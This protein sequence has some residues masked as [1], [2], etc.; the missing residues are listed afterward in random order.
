M[1]NQK[2]TNIY[3]LLSE[4][5]LTKAKDVNEFSKW[6]AGSNYRQNIYGLLKQSK[7]KG[8]GSGY[9]EFTELTGYGKRSSSPQTQQAKDVGSGYFGSPENTQNNVPSSIAR[10]DNYSRPGSLVEQLNQRDKEAEEAITKPLRETAKKVQNRQFTPQKVQYVDENDNVVDEDEV[11]PIMPKET[12]ED[13]LNRMAYDRLQAA[14]KVDLSG[15]ISRI[16]K[17][18]DAAFKA[19]G[20]RYMQKMQE[21]PLAF[22]LS[23]MSPQSAPAPGQAYDFKS[24]VEQDPEYANKFAALQL[25]KDADYIQKAAGQSKKTEGVGGWFKDAAYGAKEAAKKVSTW[26]NGDSTVRTFGPLLNAANKF[27]RGEQL[28]DSE[29]ELLEA[30]AI[31]AAYNG[32]YGDDVSSGVKAGQITV[33]ALPFMAEMLA[34]PASGTGKA[35]QKKFV[36]K[37]MTELVKG[38][39]KSIAKKQGRKAAAKELAKGTLARVGGDLLGAAVMAGTTGAEGV[40]GDTFRRMQGQSQYGVDENGNIQ[41][42]GR[43]ENEENPLVAA[44][45]AFGARTIENHSEMVGAY[46]GPVLGVAGE[47]VA[48]GLS[49]M[50]LGGVVDFIKSMGAT[51]GAKLVDNFFEKTKWD[52]TIGEYAEEV[53]GGIENAL[54][55]GDQTLDRDPETGVFNGEQNLET[56][57]SVALMGGFMSTLHTGT[58]ALSYTKGKQQLNRAEYLASES[59]GDKWSGIKQEIDKSTDADASKNLNQ[60]LSDNS[61]SDEQ[62]AAVR[63]YAKRKETLRGVLYGEEARK[64]ER[65]QEKAATR[66]S[67]I[68][69][70]DDGQT[71]VQ[72]NQNGEVI[73]EEKFGDEE[74]AKAHAD[75][76][77]MQRAE[78]DF[79]D[80]L[81][82]AIEASEQRR[83]AVENGT[84]DDFPLSEEMEARVRAMAMN[85]I[86]P[87]GVEEGSPEYEAF[88]RNM[89]TPGT[90]ENDILQEMMDSFDPLEDTY[91]T[92][93]VLED[94]DR[95]EIDKAIKT[96]PVKRTERQQKLVSEVAWR[97]HQYNFPKGELHPEQS[98]TDGQTQAD[99]DGAGTEYAMPENMV[100]AREDMEE[101]QTALDDA[102]AQNS[103]LAG[104]VNETINANEPMS[105]EDIVAG[106]VGR[107]SDEERR[108]VCDF[109]NAQSRLQ[110]YLDFTDKKMRQFVTRETSKRA[111]KGT[112]N[113]AQQ[114]NMVMVSDGEHTYFLVGGDVSTDEN[115]R[116]IGDGGKG[117]VVVDEQGNIVPMGVDASLTIMPGQTY[118][119]YSAGLLQQMQVKTTAEMGYQPQAPTEQPSPN[120]SEEGNAEAQP[121][122]TDNG[123]QPAAEAGQEQTG[124]N[125]TAGA[126]PVAPAGEPAGTGAEMQQQAVEEETTTPPAQEIPTDKEGV[127]LYEQGVNVDDAIGDIQNDGFDPAQYADLAINEAQ[128]ELSKMKEPK[129]RADLVKNNARRKELQNTIDY[130]TSLKERYSAMQS[131]QQE[132]EQNVEGEE[133]VNV[134]EVENNESGKELSLQEQIERREFKGRTADER[135][136][137]RIE[138]LKA[139]Y[140]DLFDDDF[141]YAQTPMELASMFVGRN[142]MLSRESLES[143]LGYPL[144]INTDEAWAETLLAKKGEGKT[145]KEVAHAAWESSENPIVDEK[146]TAR[147][148]DDK[149]IHDALLELFRSADNKSDV[150][151]YYINSR[152]EAAKRALEGQKRAAAEGVAA[153]APLTAAEIEEM[154]ATLPFAKPVE[155][156]DIPDSP[157]TQLA[158]AVAELS[159]EEGMPEIGLVDTDRMSD[160]DWYEITSRLF[161]GAF[162]SQ[163]EI[164]KVR[165]T[166]LADGLYIVDDTGAITIYSDSQTPEELKYK[167]E[168]IKNENNGRS[169][170]EKAGEL[171]TENVQRPS[172]GTPAVEA[173]ETP[174]EGANGAASR[175]E[176][177]EVEDLDDPE[178]IGSRISEDGETVEEPSSNGTVYKQDYLIDGKHKVTKV[179]EPDAKRNYTGSYYMFDGKRYG[180]LNEIVREID[181]R[182]EGKPSDT[183][184]Q[185]QTDEYLQ[186][187]NAEE[188]AI[189]KGVI[190]QLQQEIDAAVKERDKAASALEKARAKESDKATDMFSDDNAFKQEGQLFDSSEMPTDRSQEGVNRRTSAERERL[191]EAQDKL[192]KL[193]SE[194]ERNSRIRGAL[195]NERRQTRIRERQNQERKKDIVPLQNRSDEELQQM[196]KSMEDSVGGDIKK[197]DGNKEYSDIVNILQ[198]R[199]N[200][201]QHNDVKNFIE[202]TIDDGDVTFVD[203]LTPTEFDKL[204]S[205]INENGV[206]DAG[207]EIEKYVKSLREKYPVEQTETPSGEPEGTVADKPL[208]SLAEVKK[209]MDEIGYKGSLSRVM[210]NNEGKKFVKYQASGSVTPNIVFGETTR[211]DVYRQFHNYRNVMDVKIPSDID[212]EFSREDASLK[213][214]KDALYA[215]DRDEIKDILTEAGIPF[216]DVIDSERGSRIVFTDKKN[217]NGNYTDWMD[218]SDPEQA[219][220]DI[221]FVKAK[222]ERYKS[223]SLQA[224]ETVAP[225]MEE[226]KDATGVEEPKKEGKNPSGNK[227]V[228][229]ERYEELKKRM[230]DKLLG[231]MN[232]GVDPEILAIGVEMAVYHIEKGARK[233]ADFARDMIEDLGDVIRPYLKAFYNGARDLPE[234]E[235]LSKEMDDYGTVQSFDV[236][237]FDKTSADPMEQAKEIRDE[238]K[239]N[240]DVQKAKENIK[241]VA[242]ENNKKKKNISSQQ[243]AAKQQQDLFNLNTE[244]DEQEVRRDEGLPAEQGSRSE[245]E[246]QEG[247]EPERVREGGSS[248]PNRPLQ[249]GLSDTVEETEAE[250][251]PHE[252]KNQRNNRNE[253]GKDYAP[254]SAT[255]RVKANIAAIKLLKQL[256]AEDR[257][258]TPEEM[259]VLKQYSGWGGL[260]GAFNE[261]SP[262]Y[263][264]VRDVLDDAEYDSAAM[265]INSA[266]YTP[267]SVIDRLWDVATKL[268]FKGGNILESSAG[269]GNIIASI[270]ESMNERSNIEMVE[271]DSISGRI[272]AKLYPD[273]KVNIKGFEDTRIENGSVD[274]AITNVPFVTGLKVRDEVDTDL[275]RQFG[276]IHDFVIAKNIRKLK[277]G[278]IG[279]F[280]TTSNTLDKSDSL[281]EW[282]DGKGD[283]DV[284]GVFRLNNET[285]GGTKV[286]SD[287]IVVRKRVNGERHPDAIDVMQSS[288]IR[289]GEYE[290]QDG[291]YDWKTGKYETKRTSMRVNNYLNEH[292]EDM[293]GE[294]AFGY[295]KGDT[296]RP[297]SYGLYPS[298]KNQEQLL[299]A[300]VQK[301]KNVFAAAKQQPTVK[302]E[303]TTVR[304]G[305]MFVK[306][307]K[308]YVSQ[309]G[310]AVPYAVKKAKVKGKSVEECVKDYVAIRESLGDVLKYQLDNESDKGLKPLLDKLNKAY[311]DFVK[312]YG[313]LHKNVAISFL[314]D[315]IEFPDIAALENYSESKDIEGNKIVR[316]GKSKVFEGR[317]LR[318]K[319]EPKP[320]TVKDGVLASVQQFGKIDLGWIAK[321]VPGQTEASVRTE[322]LNSGYGFEDPVTKKV[323]VRYEYLSGNVREKLRQARENNTD[324]RYNKNIEALEKVLPMD[325]PAHLI[326]FSLGSS[327]IDPKL[328]E[329][330]VKDK[331]GCTVRLVNVGG[332][333]SMEVL[334]GEYDEKNRAGGVHSELLGDTIP[335][336]K[337]FEAAINNRTYKVQRTF[338]DWDGSKHTETDKAATQ[339]CQNRIGEIKDEFNEWAKGR[340]QT[341]VEMAEKMMRVYNDKFNSM[342]PKEVDDTFVPE[343]FEGAVDYIHL[344]PHQSKAVMRAVTEPVMLAHQVGAGKTFTLITTAMEMRRLGTAKKPMIV[345]QNATVGQFV[346]AAKVLYPN[347]KILSLTE[348][349][350]DA[351][352][353]RSFYGKIK[354]NDW[355]MIVIPQSTFER[356]PDSPERQEEFIQEKI[357]D[358]LHALEAAR[359][360]KADDRMVKQ[361][362]REIDDLEQE[363]DDIALGR[364]PQKGKKGKKKDEEKTKKNTAARAKEQLD[365]HADDVMYFDDMGIDALLIDEAHEYKRLGFSTTMGRGVKGIDP[366]GSKKAAGVYL[367]TRGILK[368]NG[369][370]NVVF[371]TGTPISNTAAEIWTFMKYLMPKESMME[372]EIWYFDD[373]VHNFGKVAQSLEFATNGKFKENTRF[374]AYINKPELIRIWSTVADTVLAKDMPSVAEKLP[375]KENGKDQDVFLPQTQSLIGIMRAVRKKLEEFEKMSGAEKRANSSVPLVMYGLA[376]RA[377]IDPR[378][379]DA[380]AMDEPNSKTNKA[381]DEIVKD[382][383]ATDSYKGTVAVFCDMQN[384]PEGFNIFQEMKRKLMEKGVPENKIAIITSGMTITQKE[385][386][387]EQVNSGDIRVIMGSTQT[388]GTG[389]NI[390]ERLHLLIHM[391]APDRP[392]DYTQRNG[393]ILRQGNLHKEW[394]RPIRIL[395]F[396]V[397]DSLDVTSYQRLKTKSGFIDSIMD[398]KGALANNQVDRTLEE[399][400]EGLFDNPV[401]VLSG[402]QYALKKTQAERELRKWQSKKQQWEAD[403]IY[404]ENTIRR[405]NGQNKEAEERIK[406]YDNQIELAKKHFPD[407]KAKTITVKGVE[408]KTE[409]ELQK[410][411]SEQVGKPIRER[412]EKYRNDR[413]FTG[414][415]VKIPMKFDDVNVVVEVDIERETEYVQ[416]KGLKTT[417]HTIYRYNIPELGIDEYSIPRGFIKDIVNDIKEDISAQTTIDRREFAQKGIEKRTADNEQLEARRSPTFKDE[418]KLES[419]R[420]KVDEYTEEMRKEMA[421]KEA[422]YAAMDAEDVDL[423]AIEDNAEEEDDDSGTRLREIEEN[424]DDVNERFNRE[425]KMQ[426]EGTLPA[427]HVYYL[428]MP[429]DAL[430]STDFPNVPI[431]LSASHL[432]DKAN[433]AHHPFD[434]SEMK[435]LVK[436]LQSPMAVFVYGD[437]DKSQNVIVEIEHDGKQFVVGIHFNQKR[438]GAIVSDIRGLYPKDNAEWLNWI[439][440]GKMLYRDKKKIQALINKQRRTLAEVDYLDLNSVANIIENFENPKLSDKKS[441]EISSE[442]VD[443]RR[444]TDGNGGTRLREGSA[445]TQIPEQ[446]SPT[447]SLSQPAEKMKEHL[448]KLSKKIGVKVVFHDDAS[449]ITNAKVKE[450]LQKGRFVAGWYDPKDN[451]VHF[452]M[453]N[454]KDRYEAEKTILHEVVG[455]KGMRALLGEEGYRTFM[456][457]LWMDKSPAFE[458]MHQWVV[459]NYMRYGGNLYETM[460]EWFAYNVVEPSIPKTMWDKVMQ[461]MGDVL[462]KLGFM[463]TPN[464]KDMKYMLWLSK[465]AIREG[466]A[467]SE[468][469]RNAL[470]AKLDLETRRRAASYSKDAA[471][472]R[473]GF[474]NTPTGETERQMY[475]NGLMRKMFAWTEAH[476]DYMA[477]AKLLM[478]AILKGRSVLDKFNF[479]MKENHSD[480]KI[481]IAEDQYVRDFCKPMED[482]I[483]KCI[484]A[485]GGK[486]SEAYE[487]LED[488]MAMKHG[489][490]RN[491]EFFVRDWLEDKRKKTPTVKD[492][493]EEAKRDFESAA[494]GIYQAFEDGQ[495]ETEA[496]RDSELRKALQDSYSSMLD[497]IEGGWAATKSQPTDNLAEWLKGLD[498]YI[499]EHID[500]EYNPNEHDYSGLTS[501]NDNVNANLN[502]NEEYD[503]DAVIGYVM[504]M[505]GKMG[506]ENVDELWKQKERMTQFALDIEHEAGLITDK[507]YKKVSQMFHWYM[508]LRKWDEDM[509][510]DIWSYMNTKKSTY[511]GN[512]LMKAKGRKSRAEMPIGTMFAMGGNAI[513]RAA[514]NEVKKSFA[515]FVRKYE[516]PGEDALVTELDAWVENLG[517]EENPDWVYS[518]PDIPEGASQDEIIQA[519]AEWSQHMLD[520]MQEGRAKRVIQGDSIPYRFENKKR[521]RP[522]HIVEVYEDGR[523]H[524]FIV[525]DNP[526][527]A[528]AING[529]LK[530]ETK[531]KL[532]AKVNR[533]MSSVFTSYSPT[534]MARNAFRDAEFAS[535]MLSVKEGW[536][537]CQKFMKN[538]V[539]VTNFAGKR[540][541]MFTLF[542]KFR[543]GTLDDSNKM[544]RYFKEFAENGGITGY[545]MENNAERWEKEILAGVKE[546]GE[547]KVVGITKNIV[548]KF[549]EGVEHAGEAIENAAR[550]ATY[551]TSREDGRTITKSVNDAKEVSVNFNRKGAGYKTESLLNDKG[552][553][554]TSAVWA[555]KTAQ[556]MRANTLFYNASLQGIVNSVGNAVRKPWWFAAKFAIPPMV[557][558]ALIPV[559]NAWVHAMLDDDDDKV[560]K[561]PYADLPEYTRRMNMCLYIGHGKFLMIPLSIEHR[562]FFGLGDIMA[563]QT[564]D[565]RLKSVDYPFAVD[566]VR[567]MT[568]FSPVD[569]N[570]KE[571]GV[572]GVTGWGVGIITPAPI[573]PLVNA[574]FNKSWTGS[575]IQ[576][577]NAYG[578]SNLPE[579]QKAKD[580]TNKTLIGASRMWHELWGGDEA[581]RAGRNDDNKY[582]EWIG[583]ISPAKME[584]VVEQYFGE[585]GKLGTGVSDMYSMIFGDKDADLRKIPIVKAFMT[586]PNDN[587]QFRRANTKYWRY[588]D[589]FKEVEQDDRQYRARIETN[590]DLKLEYENKFK[591]TKRYKQ[592][593]LYDPGKGGEGFKYKKTIEDLQ[594][595]INAEDDPVQK[596]G[597]T[598]EKNAYVQELVE[599]LDGVE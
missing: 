477:S 135:R 524:F 530:P 227:L 60:I 167:V 474:T 166:V 467:W 128:T 244:E 111:F 130:Y 114:E 539:K 216:A 479:Y 418:D 484:A 573:S 334:R 349:D 384:G 391:D 10:Q 41:Y 355:D 292:P 400:E 372:Q 151:D 443:A 579:Y 225:S 141:S 276:N 286:T 370:K 454:I 64:K 247:G 485:I 399:E 226:I 45:K 14:N 469:Q 62:K 512:T 466:D 344:Y 165:D 393:R 236:A 491:R 312:K 422:K 416:G 155:G 588:R 501:F 401:A 101:A 192:N 221:A 531:H 61:L 39:V 75:M 179:D 367:K 409:E 29:R 207:G 121:Q 100:H 266:Y 449:T 95:D 455:H 160:D 44:A 108:V 420:K 577:E 404:I 200:E 219:R 427:G 447:R 456:R 124:A 436:A 47:A 405:N 497:R 36:S 533:F 235:E 438:H 439:T 187:R 154:E 2:V 476:Q 233:F 261:N 49:K 365:R 80:D 35:L 262:Y 277:E 113:G 543:D 288:V 571:T 63:E 516:K 508:P 576:R 354:Y 554:T 396:G 376:K 315:D 563:G 377:A 46:F 544:E 142:R 283:T 538:Y 591:K 403:Q 5:G 499:R 263:N 88:V 332:T 364:E 181:S 70:A 99:L 295:E 182:A 110:G 51:K 590:P 341:D 4:N 183:V 308:I 248:E 253:R 195:D 431:E 451:S 546:I 433:T 205:L 193:Q 241:V 596:K 144:G 489:L 336:S 265:S 231:Q 254:T 345:V 310:K 527:A 375:E 169:N 234:M 351:E 55:V 212:A 429:S 168:Y 158:K 140:G 102:M 326:D 210:T 478:D 518:F 58:G 366:A 536:D 560:S 76:L 271:I 578:G 562:A 597:L 17:E 353:R 245:S 173:A 535:S 382:L 228:T 381:T 230:R 272:L 67:N 224:M 481:K 87:E 94:S 371:A 425:L 115:G 395:R 119:D 517:T 394:G 267:A 171:E 549:M 552:E 388:L 223:D 444:K 86:I 279:I 594:K 214:I 414:A 103:E 74:E 314:R 424:I 450:A 411:L 569:Y 592:W 503:D 515:G 13:E 274:L 574:Y 426:V 335:A 202:G 410:A 131:P 509:A 298:E 232:V 475:K 599:L 11:Y 567:Q 255:A 423:D 16:E 323:E 175:G 575:Q 117:I 412:V 492:L 480:S 133:N 374:A 487:I 213:E 294:M 284:M 21:N 457:R 72:T 23:H 143:E 118:D 8:I 28:T 194:Q 282:I 337:L 559:F 532:T 291:K 440:Q 293:G 304:E 300:W 285:F 320:Q 586:L 580:Y 259:D 407:G 156:E 522:E 120:P 105:P 570:S 340:M 346:A 297:G 197:L 180:D 81:A 339:A 434:I 273:A 542:R 57:L 71:V 309:Q 199:E 287:I 488:Y 593:K 506:K 325:I 162:V 145:T 356:I 307:G 148:F 19:A 66:P 352:G 208:T 217:D 92:V 470:L 598:Q 15:E 22:A 32:Q 264:E 229:D 468:L 453:P 159:K 220:E 379:V 360:A 27:D 373:F 79:Q 157:I 537:Y 329:D 77:K 257:D 24:E 164:D 338:K 42:S 343:Q 415:T 251:Q 548:K 296:F 464:M 448:T 589:E 564:Y 31:N 43:E 59:L 568:A 442:E 305:R 137:A 406:E 322:I 446:G 584:Y 258:A 419:A 572:E 9:G 483:N 460:D 513:V 218:V 321:N 452:Y 313:Y 38:M 211:R 18:S 510:E 303:D 89:D 328:Y 402:S 246:G 327:W 502:D 260:G 73:G 482:A 106:M 493:D 520:L 188:E 196:K 556:Y 318:F 555:A 428:G 178:G 184:A 12:A 149:E 369:W 490:E 330:F 185:Q 6:M 190:E 136:R 500:E 553:K 48:K 125:E 177:E 91:E 459:E 68:D 269:I 437:K 505:E 7:V 132:T 389:V 109:I 496:E 398:G 461:V 275:S 547:N 122:P 316:V 541:L 465:N 201:R 97:L 289:D 561:D 150:I 96:D 357:D 521:S 463:N 595:R 471:R 20:D 529:K 385:K 186:P 397:E 333:W 299:D 84:P 528:Q 53:V 445:A 511:V 147:K 359:R 413:T 582:K 146:T 540:P 78:Q 1:A 342:V 408:T 421:E 280:I 550:F 301:M 270:P 239:V 50:K 198:Q 3:N 56:F 430:L 348:R 565:E 507:N 85:Q 472:A 525:N 557:M 152:E 116:I 237:N 566:A 161:G 347:A 324:G 514:R 281:R 163:E 386:I 435:G 252:K 581:V 504:D 417:M 306:D 83:Q 350:R 526:R 387:F 191:N 311:D 519:K 498:D 176:D 583:E 462:H 172:E 222:A 126:A 127:K 250:P 204:N 319:T 441:S 52:G 139:F 26:D 363:R 107:F 302:T 238:A 534:F 361:M 112:L 587:T 495:I 432:K 368:N 486:Y 33:E 290:N 390:Q 585:P 82:M 54:V 123:A 268:G 65:A 25:L 494:R 30:A 69:V 380:G 378:L 189:I 170:E 90:A 37:G 278:G 206:D 215:S 558:G 383:A 242:K 317:V 129:T 134:P 362:E 104:Y 138:A 98:F 331:Y 392:M 458:E 34:N 358:K 153:A 174:A 473:D 249:S 240:K 256:E 93:A 243:E 40:A 523:P 209:F 203:K 545:V 551:V